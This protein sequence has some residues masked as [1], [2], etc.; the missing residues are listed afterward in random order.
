MVVLNACSVGRLHESGAEMVGFTSGFHLSGAASIVTCLWPVDDIVA[1]DFAKTS[2]SILLSAYLSKD[3]NKEFVRSKAF[4]QTLRS[5][6]QKYNEE[7]LACY[8]YYGV[9]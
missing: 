8:F 2:S 7:D 4:T 1:A 6:S 5:L 9:P 3:L